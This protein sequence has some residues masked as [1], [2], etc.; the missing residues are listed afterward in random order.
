MSPLEIGI[1]S[2]ENKHGKLI[3]DTLHRM[4]PF[5]ISVAGGTISPVLEMPFEEERLCSAG[6]IPIRKAEFAAGRAYARAA[7]EALG[8]R[9]QSI[10]VAPDRRPIWPTGFVGSITHSGLYCAV[11][12]APSSSYL[13][14]GI[15]FEP[16]I[17]LE[18]RLYTLVGR[19]E[20][21]REFPHS[22]RTESGFLDRG[23]LVFSAKEAVF[24]ACYPVCLQWF[25]FLDASV[26]ICTQG[27]RFTATIPT[28]VLGKLRS[29][30]LEGHWSMVA[31]NVITS[32]VIE[33]KPEL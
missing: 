19:D 2:P 11:A 10:P 17:P 5:D 23:K 28:D 31:G 26:E 20:E 9:K 8:C 30:V 13:G 4:L 24:K 6:M 33:A 21:R 7:L 27:N 18:R 25:D 22:I 29:P 32:I 1:Q 3:V 12:A 15:D 16:A 14:I